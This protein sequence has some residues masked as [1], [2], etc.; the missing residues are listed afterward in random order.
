MGGGHKSPPILNLKG[1]KMTN[2]EC[3]EAVQRNLV[4]MAAL[5]NVE[6]KDSIDIEGI[7]IEVS[8]EAKIALKHAVNTLKVDCITTLNQI[9]L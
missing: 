3:I 6:A 1:L 4:K 9:R 5:V 7:A 8:Q 2:Q